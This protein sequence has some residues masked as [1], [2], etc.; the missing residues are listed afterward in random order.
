[1]DS[2]YTLSSG[3]LCSLN[4]SN[5]GL[6]FLSVLGQ[7]SYAVKAILVHIQISYFRLYNMEILVGLKLLY[8]PK[9]NKH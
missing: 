2:W 8:A 5:K 9:F 6:P 7:F 4:G 1:M 3:M